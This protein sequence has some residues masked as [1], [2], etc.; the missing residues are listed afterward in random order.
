MNMP[1]T[2]LDW[3]R[4]Q[5]FLAVAEHGSLSAAARALGQSQ[6]TLGRHIKSFEEDLGVEVFHRHA[7]GFSLTEAGERMVPAARKMQTAMHDIVL[8]ADTGAN[9]DTGTVRIACSVHVAHHVLP[10]IIAELRQTAPGIDLVIDASDD[11]ENLLFREADIALRMYRPRQLDLIT[12]HIADIPMGA[13]AAVS[14][15]DARG[16]PSSTADLRHH[17]LI[18][19]DQAPLIRN[20]LARLGILESDL[21]FPVRCDNQTAYWQLVRAGCGIGFS[22]VDTGRRDP[23]VEQVPLGFDLP[24][25]PLWLTAHEAVRRI[26]RVDMIWTLLAQALGA[27]FAPY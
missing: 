14:Y 19:Y 27:R 8:A 4:V 15:L 22:Q 11:S 1:I 7:R 9:Q 12:R 26:P 23:A 25:L 20:E 16:R 21:H 5:A 24:N 13:F 17:D 18:G 3:S 2:S 6:P 10:P